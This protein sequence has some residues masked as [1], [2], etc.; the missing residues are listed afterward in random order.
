MAETITEADLRIGNYYFFAGKIFRMDLK[1]MFAFCGM[2]S[3][4]IDDL[5]G[6]PLLPGMLDVAGFY[7]HPDQIFV[8]KSCRI[9]VRFWSHDN[10]H[11]AVKPAG[12]R[13][14]DPINILCNILYLSELQ[15][16]Y[17]FLTREEMKIK[18]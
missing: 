9:V 3:Y 7:E 5:S 16:L 18:L 17:Y 15:S 8:D 6:I 2:H 12:S 1:M 11:V 13:I 4:A 10:I 14:I